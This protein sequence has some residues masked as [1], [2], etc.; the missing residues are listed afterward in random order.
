[1]LAQGLPVY[2]HAIGKDKLEAEHKKLYFQVQS[3]NYTNL[4]EQKK[5]TEIKAPIILAQVKMEN[6]KQR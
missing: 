1:M 2:M 5:V 4:L 3:C 6:E